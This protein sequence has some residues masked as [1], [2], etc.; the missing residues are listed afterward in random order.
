MLVFDVLI[1]WTDSWQWYVDLPKF[2]LDPEPGLYLCHFRQRESCLIFTLSQATKQRQSEC[3]G[4]SSVADTVRDPMQVLSPFWMR[5]LDKICS[6]F[7]IW[8]LDHHLHLKIL[9]LG[10]LIPP[11]RVCMSLKRLIYSFNKHILSMDSQGQWVLVPGHTE[12]LRMLAHRK[13]A[14]QY[15]ATEQKDSVSK[16]EATCV[17]L[18]WI[19]PGRITGTRKWRVSIYPG[20]S[21]LHHLRVIPTLSLRPNPLAQGLD[22][23]GQ[24]QTTGTSNSKQP[25]Q[26]CGQRPLVTRPMS[27]HPSPHMGRALISMGVAACPC[28]KP[29]SSFSCKWMTMGC[30]RLGL[31]ESSLKED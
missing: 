23:H 17:S 13:R 14:S 10:P 9:P 22:P 7:W 2:S 24:N 15:D 19:F 1:W 18:H 31:P 29:V 12:C 21:H 16:W 30:K 28:E 26:H 11:I 6:W 4:S 25:N 8:K 20:N 27:I 5:N 3:V